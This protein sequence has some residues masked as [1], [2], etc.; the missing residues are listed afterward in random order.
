M[1][2]QFLKFFVNFEGR[3]W[4]DTG[5]LNVQATFTPPFGKGYVD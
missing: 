5:T 4:W 3:L 1:S 2:E